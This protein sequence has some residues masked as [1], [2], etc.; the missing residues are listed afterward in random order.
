MQDQP[1]QPQIITIMDPNHLPSSPLQ[2]QHR[3]SDPRA[4][5]AAPQE[6]PTSSSDT[7]NKLALPTS[8]NTANA[9]VNTTAV[10]P[11]WQAQEVSALQTTYQHEPAGVVYD[12]SDPWPEN[13]IAGPSSQP[14]EPPLSQPLATTSRCPTPTPPPTMELAPDAAAPSSSLLT[15]EPLNRS[16]SSASTTP[17][18]VL[19]P[20]RCPS[21][22]STSATPNKLGKRARSASLPLVIP[23]IKRFKHHHGPP[24]PSDQWKWALREPKHERKKLE[25]AD[26]AAT[27]LRAEI[28]AARRARKPTSVIIASRGPPINL[29]TLKSL[30]ADEILK[31]PQLRHDLLFDA[32][33]FKP[34]AL[35]PAPGS[36]TAGSATATTT[37]TAT[38]ASPRSA[39]VGVGGEVIP[40]GVDPTND[41]RAM[42][43][44]ADM[45][46]ESIASEIA[47]GCRCS[48]WRVD[49]VEGK[50]DSAAL[51]AKT[52]E[53]G[54]LCGAWKNDLTEAG[55]WEWQANKLPSRLPELIK[56]ESNLLNLSFALLTYQRCGTFSS[57]SWDPRRLA[58]HTLPI[59]SPAK[60]S[61]LTRR[62]ARL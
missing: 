18:P 7:P 60:L 48:R 26:E 3:H 27:G 55:W 14:W 4:D 43:A 39:T 47:T 9:S 30:D 62:H 11:Q 52:K 25:R 13:A 22:R 10:P 29:C 12:T 51:V 5:N 19:V 57:R 37:A 1:R 21:P 16:T 59:H 58:H 15:S 24:T 33:S 61:L 44:M 23:D 53:K 56:S 8:N 54:C 41:P 34:V 38:P 2:H 28:D 35:V 45:Y 42:A 50:I 46:W 49:G 6:R 36:T 40:A 17:F 32:L 31:N 20:S